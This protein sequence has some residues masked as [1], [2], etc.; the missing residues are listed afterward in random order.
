M[1]DIQLYLLEY[2]KNKKEATSIAERS[3][4]RMSLPPAFPHFP[5]SFRSYTDIW[6]ILG[7]QDKQLKLLELI[8]GLGE[9]IASEDGGIR[10]KSK[11]SSLTF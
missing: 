8:E 4:S 5:L 2:D 6:D 11:I 3:A 10:G 7:L 9:Y 1:S